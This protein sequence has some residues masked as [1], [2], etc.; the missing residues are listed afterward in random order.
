MKILITGA[1]GFVGKTLVP[2][3][4]HHLLKDICLL[5]RDRGKAEH[6]F[7]DLNV[8]IIDTTE[9]GWRE[10]VIGY[11]PDVVFHMAAFFTG[12]SDET[13]IEKLIDSN[14]LF[15][16]RLLESISHT[17]CHHFINIGT[18]TEYLNGAGEY[19][20]NNL[21]SATKSA[22]RPIIKYYQTQSCWNWIN[23]VV[24]SPYGRYNSSKKV[25]DYLVDAAGSEVP[26][27]FS[28]GNQVLDF[29][30]VDDIAD[31]FYTLILS[32]D[33]LKD[34]YY[35]FH[36]GTGKGHSVREVAEVIEEVGGQPVNANWGGRAYSSSD[37]MHAVAP[38]NSNITLLG[39][40]FSLSLREGIKILYE[41]IKVNK[42][43]RGGGG[44]SPSV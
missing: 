38:I 15:T 1:T 36:L 6:L 16:T 10:Q 32:L 20:P 24:Y 43:K 2:Y 44:K 31:F 17:S 21:Y 5:V 18:F 19:L 25:I 27:D 35:Q 30:H 11:S 8:G 7:S 37:T 28:P 42:C 39:W 29:I 13:S 12:K 40:H 26:V 9:N 41:D 23:V 33:N 4:F 14:I 22:V 3:L 34:S